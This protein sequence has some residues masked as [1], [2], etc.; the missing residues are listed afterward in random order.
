VV[1]FRQHVVQAPAVHH[2]HYLHCEFSGSL[3]IVCIQNL[4]D[5]GM[6]PEGLGANP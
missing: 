3:G 2:P 6:D 4:E 5:L 1:L